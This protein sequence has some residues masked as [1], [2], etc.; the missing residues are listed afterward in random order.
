[1]Y[2]STTSCLSFRRSVVGMVLCVRHLVV[3]VISLL[4]D[5]AGHEMMI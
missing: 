5:M 1:V 3:V 4:Q 2:D